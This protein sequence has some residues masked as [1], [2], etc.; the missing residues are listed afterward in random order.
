[1]SG[2]W[3]IRHGE[4]ESNAGLPSL[5]D[6]DTPLT[7]KGLIEANLVA[8]SVTDAPDRFV[9]SPYIR[10]MQTASPTL[11]KFPYVPV[12]T[13]PVQEY[14]YLSHEQYFN[15]TPQVRRKMSEAY[16]LKADPDL[17]LGEGGESFSQFIQRVK[18]SLDRLIQEETD[19]TIIF[20]HGWFMRAILWVLYQE[21]SSKMEKKQFLKILQRIMVHTPWVLRLW[22]WMDNRKHIKKMF[23]F[24]I[25]SAAV[26]TPN[27]AI[28]KFEVSEGNVHLAAY[29]VSHLPDELRET[30]LINR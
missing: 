4:S 28:L 7:E 27:C 5:S 15:T 16:F 25:F 17:V 24:L 6:K 21:K 9:V 26:Q 23:S 13:W 22:V 19:L 3:F 14:S 2:F 1:M 12:E 30:T 29:D 8:N 20:G 18:T 11:L 10:T